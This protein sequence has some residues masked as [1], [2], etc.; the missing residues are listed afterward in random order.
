M[1]FKTIIYD[2]VTPIE[3]ILRLMG[4]VL[5]Q[6]PEKEELKKLRQYPLFNNPFSWKTRKIPK[7]KIDR[8]S[9]FYQGARRSKHSDTKIFN[10]PRH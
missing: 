10:H 9:K 4:K 6:C 5:N 2:L 8:P 1:D 7:E 3:K